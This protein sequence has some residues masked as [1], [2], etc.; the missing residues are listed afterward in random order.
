MFCTFSI[1]DLQ[2]HLSSSNGRAHTEASF[3]FRKYYRVWQ[4]EVKSVRSFVEKSLAEEESKGFAQDSLGNHQKEN[5]HCNASRQCTLN[6]KHSLSVYNESDYQLN[7]F[8]DLSIG[9]PSLT[10]SSSLALVHISKDLYDA[11]VLTNQDQ[12]SLHMQRQREFKNPY[13]I[14]A[15]KQSL[16][17]LSERFSTGRQ[18]A[19]AGAHRK[20]MATYSSSAVI[21]DLQEYLDDDEISF[22][23]SM[24][25][26]TAFKKR[27]EYNLDN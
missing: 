6:D 3:L 10:S 27:D 15:M 1:S 9:I 20:T 22:L 25:L 18:P 5:Q 17:E 24:N 19:S 2:V 16:D 11:P 26:L 23:D 7:V 4:S 21:E 13:S 8:T 14:T 12:L